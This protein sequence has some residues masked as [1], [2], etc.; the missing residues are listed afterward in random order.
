MKTKKSWKNDTEYEIQVILE[1]ERKTNRGAPKLLGSTANPR[2]PK[3]SFR[4]SEKRRQ[5]YFRIEKIQV[6]VF[7]FFGGSGVQHFPN[8]FGAPL[9]VFS[10]KKLK[11]CGSKSL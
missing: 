6:P 10:F 2:T 4:I 5:N 7:W 3:E 9:F 1:N 11:R 8:N